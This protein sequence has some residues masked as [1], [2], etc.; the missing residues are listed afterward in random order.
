MSVRREV[1]TML[2]T[3][4]ATDPVLKKFRVMATEA[5]LEQVIEPTA[6]IRTKSVQRDPSAPMSSRKFGFLL[7]LISPL[8]D[9]DLA[10]DDLEDQTDAAINYLGSRFTLDTATYVGYDGYLAVDIPFFVTAKNA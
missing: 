3:D 2:R 4:W 1:E 6:L 5:A 8:N 7:T 10:G 9:L